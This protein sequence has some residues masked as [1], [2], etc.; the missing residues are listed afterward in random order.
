[1][2]CF[3]LNFVWWTKGK[4]V[5][6]FIINDT[7]K[8]GIECCM[9]FCA[10]NKSHFIAY[11][12]SLIMNLYWCSANRSLIVVLLIH[13]S[14]IK[15]VLISTVSRDTSEGVALNHFAL[16]FSLCSGF[17]RPRLLDFIQQHSLD[18]SAKDCDAFDKC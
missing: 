5:W 3:P 2:C 10:F 9:K 6:N 16:P 11:L 18:S 8:Y 17:P 1:M 12:H 15:Y 14:V 7:C 13:I 4:K